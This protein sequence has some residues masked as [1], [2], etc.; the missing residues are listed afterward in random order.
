MRG[1]AGRKKKDSANKPGVSS[2]IPVFFSR[3]GQKNYQDVFDIGFAL[4]YYYAENKGGKKRKTNDGGWLAKMNSSISA[5]SD[6]KTGIRGANKSTWT[7]KYA[8]VSRN[9]SDCHFTMWKGHFKKVS[10]IFIYFFFV[11]KI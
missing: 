1:R 9:Y 3:N 5:P 2:V 6:K 10:C 4:N 8:C 11:G 7:Y